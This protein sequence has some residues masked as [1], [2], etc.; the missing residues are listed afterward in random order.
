MTRTP[1]FIPLELLQST[2]F[3]E[4]LRDHALMRDREEALLRLAALRIS[5]D[6]GYVS[7]R[8]PPVARMLW[9]QSLAVASGIPQAHALPL[10][11][12]DWS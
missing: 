11:R 3:A 9:R 12:G 7:K 5:S 10:T 6:V 2:T 1:R 8:P 4:R